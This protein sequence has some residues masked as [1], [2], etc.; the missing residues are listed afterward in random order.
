MANTA[1]VGEV[2]QA[3]RDLLVD[4]LRRIFGE[5][6]DAALQQVLPR[7]EWIELAGGTTLFAQGE[8]D[9]SLYLVI[10]GRLRA[11]R[12]NDEGETVALGDIARG[13]TVGEIAFFTG[14]PRMATIT[15]VRDS[16]LA[17]FSSS[18][19]RELLLA[20]PLFS[21]NITRQV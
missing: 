9:D 2:T 5:F 3:Q 13:E 12:R 4:G 18:V 1:P 14:E 7:F 6:D 15:A 10:S 20:Y 16:V 21:M 11:L 19:F 8:R 17:R